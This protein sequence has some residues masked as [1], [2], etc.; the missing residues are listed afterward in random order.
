[1]RRLAKQALQ[2]RNLLDRQ[3]FLSESDWLQLWGCKRREGR[4]T[5]PDCPANLT[6]ALFGACWVPC[7]KANGHKALLFLFQTKN[8]KWLNACDHLRRLESSSIRKCCLVPWRT[9]E[10]L[11]WQLHFHCIS[12][13]IYSSFNWILQFNWNYQTHVPPYRCFCGWFEPSVRSW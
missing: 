1:M 13:L 3:D 5:G 2:Y 6:G 8:I 10:C 12:S 9:G 4:G 7:P 11:R